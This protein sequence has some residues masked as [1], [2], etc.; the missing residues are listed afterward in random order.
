MKYTTQCRPDAATVVFYG[1]P[2]TDVASLSSLRAPVCCVYGR[3]DVQ[4]PIPLLERFQESLKEAKVD[5]DFKIYDGVGHA[6]WSDMDQVRR[7]EEPQISAYK[8][9]TSFLR[10]FFSG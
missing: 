7:E 4:F 6:F 5:N 8:Q 9:C 3:N 2:V 10:K 1:T